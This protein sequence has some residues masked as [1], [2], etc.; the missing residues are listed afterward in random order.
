MARSL[1][2]RHSLLL[3]SSALTNPPLFSKATQNPITRTKTLSSINIAKIP[4][5]LEHPLNHA[6]IPLLSCSRFS[7]DNGGKRTSA[8][9]A[10]HM[11]SLK[12]YGTVHDAKMHRITGGWQVNCTP[13]GGFWWGECTTKTLR[14]SEHGKW[15]DRST[16][17]NGGSGVLHSREPIHGLGMKTSIWILRR[18][19]NEKQEDVVEK[20][21]LGSGGAFNGFFLIMSLKGVSVVSVRTCF[22][23]F[24]SFASVL[25]YKIN[26]TWSLLVLVWIIRH[27]SV[28]SARYTK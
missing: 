9:R 24:L 14:V 19:E 3:I 20:I 25:L 1:S 13:K 4:F 27:N 5:K 23:S 21:R 22:C 26:F 28:L 12:R 6:Y 2:P 17:K 15:R 7:S 11:Q 10:I 8:K 16:D 18:G